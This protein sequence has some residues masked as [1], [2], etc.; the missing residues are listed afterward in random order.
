MGKRLIDTLQEV[1]E[2]ERL[3]AEWRRTY[4]A[5][6]ERYCDSLIEE[7]RSWKELDREQLQDVRRALRWV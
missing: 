7:A 2:A 4:G 1:I 3:A 5:D 6:A